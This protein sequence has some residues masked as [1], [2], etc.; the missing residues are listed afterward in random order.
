MTGPGQV[1]RRPDLP[2]AVRGSNADEVVARRART[3]Y[4]DP[5][6]DRCAAGIEADS[7]VDHAVAVK[8]GEGLLRIEAA[9]RR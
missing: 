6:E 3:R 7:W 4:L 8:W 5:D 1:V 2:V 9:V